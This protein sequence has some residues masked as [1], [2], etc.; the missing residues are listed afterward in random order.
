MADV[1]SV[2]RAESAPMSSV[3]LTAI[4]RRC[5]YI[6]SLYETGLDRGGTWQAYSCESDSPYHVV[7]TSLLLLTHDETARSKYTADAFR[8][9]PDPYNSTSDQRRRRG[10]KKVGG[11]RSC[12][13]RSTDALNFRQNS[14]GQLQIS[15]KMLKILT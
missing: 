9:T 15:D 14:D 7:N 3:R 13:F 1:R 4:Y 12:N 5:I 8:R 2:D 6:A 10:V 11:A